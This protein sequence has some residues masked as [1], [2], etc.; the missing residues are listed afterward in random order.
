MSRKIDLSLSE[1]KLIIENLYMEYLVREGTIKAVNNVNLTIYSGTITAIV[2]ESG[3]GKTS[4]VETILKLLPKNA[5]IRSGR[6]ILRISKGEELDLIKADENLMRKLRGR[7]IGYVPQGAQNS[8]NPVLT[9]KQ[10]FYETIKDHGMYND[11][12]WDEVYSILKL[13][14]LD[15]EEV[16][17]RYPHE[18]SGGM[19]QRVVLALTMI[20]KPELVVLDEPT[21]ALDVFS[22]R[23]LLKALYTLHETYKNTM[24]LITHDIPVAMELADRVAV[25]YAGSIVESG[26]S[27]K[28]FKE[29]LHPYTSMFISAIPSVID[30]YMKRKPKPIPGEPPSLLNPPTGCKFHPRCPFAMDICRVKEPPEIEIEAGR[31]VKCWLY[32]KK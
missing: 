5:R 28:I 24:I 16:L 9:V 8:L 29:P 15:P 26:D 31:R 11:K 12:T 22:Q 4:L 25:L 3:S 32:V 17:Q 14:K 2:G 27:Y 23:M 6:A 19:K 13:I 7:V 18:L 1:P 20:L 10:S 30:V 21:S